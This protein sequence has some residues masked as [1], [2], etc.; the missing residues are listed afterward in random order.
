MANKFS[1]HDQLSNLPTLTGGKNYPMSSCL[2]SA[3]LKHKE[4]YATVTV[5]PGNRHSGAVTKKLS[6]AAN[7]LLTDIND[8]LYNCFITSEKDNN[9]YLI[10]TR[11]HELFGKRMG[12]RLSQCLP[13]GTR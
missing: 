12:L 8:K 5:N 2:I 6:E 13:K 9:G 7:I 3:F 4:L 10:W 1:L 11:I